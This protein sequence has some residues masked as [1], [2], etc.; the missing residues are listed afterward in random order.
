MDNIRDQLVE[1]LD[2]MK[3]APMDPEVD[4]ALRLLKA[5]LRI[6]DDTTRVAL[7]RLAENLAHQ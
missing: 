6:H 7:V 1:M 5:F 2:E 3:A 4:S